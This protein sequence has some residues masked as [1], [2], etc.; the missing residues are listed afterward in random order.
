MCGFPPLMKDVLL[1]IVNTFQLSEHGSYAWVAAAHS[2]LV[3]TF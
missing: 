1:L 3:C 2:G